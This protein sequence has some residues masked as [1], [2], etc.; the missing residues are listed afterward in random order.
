MQPPKITSIFLERSGDLPL[1]V[2]TLSELCCEPT[3]LK[4]IKT[5]RLRESGL[6]GL[7][8]IFSR[9]TVLS[10][11]LTKVIIEGTGS[12]YGYCP[13]LPPLFGDI[14]TIRSL[15][16]DGISF[17]AK[18]LRFTSLTS[19]TLYILGALLPP[20]F[21]LLAVNPALESISISAWGEIPLEKV[22]GPAVTLDNLV[23]FHCRDASKH[24]LSRL[25]IPHSTS[26]QIE[27]T[28]PPLSLSGPLPASITNIRCLSQVFSLHLTT[29]T[30]TAYSGQTTDVHSVSLVG[31]GGTVDV[32]WVVGCDGLQEFDPRPL[33]LDRVRVLSI[34][35][36]TNL[37]RP[38]ASELDLSPLFNLMKSLEV[39]KIHSCLPTD[40]HFILSPLLDG[41][42]CPPLHTVEIIRCSGEVQWLSALLGLA[43]RRRDTGLAL[44]KVLISPDAS[45]GSPIRDYLKKFRGVL[46]GSA[47]IGT[48]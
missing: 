41:S 30:D 46:S 31:R 26:I 4:R 3:H 17:D 14:S 9:L 20:F 29:A 35:H 15:S 36:N 34:T 28:G 11:I 21:D 38:R 48:V 32:H 1:H 37:E 6:D 22:D 18:L 24:I 33:S 13:N 27:D 25:S 16:L 12:T 43:I 45:A 23:T 47:E 19:L 5:L 42:I 39:L 44:R 2:Y 10:P 7:A 8:E 40:R